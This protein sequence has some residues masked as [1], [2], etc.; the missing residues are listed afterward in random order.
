MKNEREVRVKRGKDIEERRR[1]DE[2]KGEERIREERKR[3]ERR[4]D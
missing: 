1:E 2:E 3:E 4:G